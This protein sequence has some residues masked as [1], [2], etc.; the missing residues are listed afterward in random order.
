[1]SK[2]LQV[3]ISEAAC[4]EI[5]A[6]TAEIDEQAEVAAVLAA[7]AQVARSRADAAKV[8][9]GF[10]IKQIIEAAGL[11]TATHGVNVERGVVR[12]VELEG[13]RNA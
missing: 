6:Y 5:L 4:A 9:R 7:D 8:K 10:L 11:S 1:M 2:A 3:N 12:I 13:K